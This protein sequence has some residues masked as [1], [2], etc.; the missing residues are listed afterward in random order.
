MTDQQADTTGL[1]GRMSKLEAVVESLSANVTRITDDISKLAEYSRNRTQT[2]WGNVFAGVTLAVM[3]V[4]GYV[5]LPLSSLTGNV[6]RYQLRNADDLAEV[7]QE[8][9][10]AKQDL[11]GHSED[12]RRVA[13][14]HE[15]RL[16]GLETTEAKNEERIHAIERHIF[17]ST[18]YNAGRPY[19]LE[20]L[21]TDETKFSTD[22]LP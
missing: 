3:L 17:R 9:R 14:K 10:R 12:N 19:R 13:E 5:G 6:E 4:A 16:D 15:R 20:G 21:R 18:V 22:R 1:A 2:Q 8:I 7:Y 11:R